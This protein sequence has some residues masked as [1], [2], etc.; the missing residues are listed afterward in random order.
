MISYMLCA[1]LLV[2][3]VKA[4]HFPIFDDRLL[5]FTLLFIILTVQSQADV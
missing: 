4:A 2:Y 1:V 3:A 5:T